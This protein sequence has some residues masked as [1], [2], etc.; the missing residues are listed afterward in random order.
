[1]EVV[2]NLSWWESIILGIVQGLTEFFPVSSDGHLVVARELLNYHKD[3]LVFD[4]FV[5]VGTLGSLLFVFHK[6]IRALLKD[7]WDYKWKVLKTKKLSFEENERWLIYVW[8]TTFITGV[9]GLLTEDFVKSTFSQIHW[10]GIGFLLTAGF[11][12][13]SYFRAPQNKSVSKQMLIFPLIIGLAQASALL[14]G[15]SRSGMTIACALL[16]GV[17][18]SESGRFSFVAAIPIIFMAS[19]YQA[20]HLLDY[21]LGEIGTML[22]GVATAFIVGVFAIKGL[23]LMLQRLSLLPFA[24]YTSLLG[25]LILVMK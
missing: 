1:M 2:A 6:D 4:V 11:L 15:V 24:I 17:P 22:I 12:Y 19:I 7:T 13:L 23:L 5:H 21:E 16:M 18:R 25:I 9:V 3:L 8:G 10:A 14:P 20:R